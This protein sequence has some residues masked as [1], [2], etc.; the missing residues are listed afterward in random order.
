LFFYDATY[1]FNIWLLVVY[2]FNFLNLFFLN[3]S[4]V[5]SGSWI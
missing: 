5:D 3:N 4:Y 1:E 2:I